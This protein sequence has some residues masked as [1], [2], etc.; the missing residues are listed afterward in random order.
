MSI[1]KCKHECPSEDQKLLT[2]ML[3]KTDSNI[4]FFVLILSVK[5]D[6]RRW[7]VLLVKMY[8]FS[9]TNSGTYENYGDSKDEDRW[10][11]WEPRGTAVPWPALHSSV[12]PATGFITTEFWWQS[13]YTSALSSGSGD[14]FSNLP[15]LLT[16]PTFYWD[17]FESSS[18]T[19]L[20]ADLW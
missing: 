6:T 12:P 1:G 13:S 3:S 14:S 17:G 16:N 9:C 18:I 2:F 11:L 19:A 8:H 7:C 4:A 5:E 15:N 20:L 10:V